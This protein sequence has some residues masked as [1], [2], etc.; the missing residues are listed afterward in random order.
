MERMMHRVET[1]MAG[2]N[3]LLI[4]C[5]TLALMAAF[6]PGTGRSQTAALEDFDGRWSFTRAQRDRDS[7][8][9]GIDHVADQLNLFIRE[10]ARG[11]MRRRI[12][13]ENR[14]VV[15]VHDETHVSL[16][17]DDWGPVRF[18]LT[19]RPRRVRGPN[20]DHIRAG[21]SFRDGRLIHREVH[22]QGHRTNVF[23][24]SANR[25][26]LTMRAVIGSDQL[27]DEVRYRLTYRRS[28]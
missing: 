25:R 12:Q 24:L 10:I 5:A 26:S 17:M 22:S 20:G 27:P 2:M 1:L 11:E 28:R 15:R 6:V 7:L 18:D 4:L 23:A 19:A 21:V 3:K 13:P 9:D 14:V 16:A 8:E